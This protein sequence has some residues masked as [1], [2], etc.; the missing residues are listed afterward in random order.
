[1]KTLGILGGMSWE[2]TAIYYQRLNQLVNG[3]LGGLHSAKL[4]MASLDFAEIEK[5]QKTG[6]WKAL[7]KILADQAWKLAMAG[8][9]GILIATNTMHK[10][11]DAIE[12]VVPLDVIHIA[13]ATGEAVK[14]MGLG[15]VGLLGT[16]FTMEEDFYKGRLTA[17]FGLDVLVP[18]DAD[19]KTVHGVIYNELCQGQCTP[20]SKAEYLQIM[21]KLVSQGA[22]G[23]ILGCTEIGMLVQQ[24]DTPIPLF[25]TTEIHAQAAV[26]WMLAEQK[27]KK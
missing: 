1:M 10:L 16:A 14:R 25:D 4:L 2:S 21:E 23:I 26:N 6:N 19:R 9:E 24:S 7:E 20:Q 12:D 27:K 15:K 17:L 5:H 18:N 13:D 3:K 22:Q 11:V 8:A